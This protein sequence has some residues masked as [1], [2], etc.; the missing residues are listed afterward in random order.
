MIFSRVCRVCGRELVSG[1]RCLCLHCVSA[2]PLWSASVDDLRAHRFPRTAPVAA[3]LPWMVYNNADPVCALIRDGKFN[4]RPE[5]IDH[6]ASRYAAWLL[7][8]GLLRDI[9]VIMPVPMHWWKRLRRGYN[10]AEIIARRISRASGIPVANA[11]R[12]VRSHAVQSR[13]SGAERAANVAGIFALTPSHG[14]CSG[15]RIALVDDILT[16]GSTLS[17]ACRALAPLSPAHITVLPLAAT[18]LS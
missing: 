8:K 4:D 9:D 11:L 1:E 6:L 15:L 12:A 7:E 2:I 18:R 16:T 10:Q 13:Q 3:V 14:L 17:E 5:L